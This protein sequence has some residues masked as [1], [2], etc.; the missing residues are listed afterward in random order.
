MQADSAADAHTS[1]EAQGEARA[2]AG[3]SSEA[4]GIDTT[5]VLRLLPAAARFLPTH[6][7]GGGDA[8]KA[9]PAQEP[10]W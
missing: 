2:E 1:G 10:L 6:S 4:G 9:V 7:D 5:A 8:Q 3:S